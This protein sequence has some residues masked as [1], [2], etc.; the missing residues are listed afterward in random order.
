MDPLSTVSEFLCL[1]SRSR[2]LYS[3]A[4]VFVSHSTKDDS[5]VNGIRQ[6][7]ESLGVE[8]W[9]DSQRLT[10]GDPLTPNVMEAI[11]RSEHFLAILSKN[12]I[13]SPWVAKEIKH[14]LAKGKKVIPILLLP[15]ETTALPLWF[16]EEPVG[17]KLS[18]GPGGLSSA[19]P[20]LLA[21]LGLRQPAEKTAALQAKLAP[22]A[23]LTLRLADPSIDRSDGK[24]RA[25]ATAALVYSPSYSGPEVE[26]LRFRF[27]APLGPI[28][29]RR[30]FLVPGALHQLAQR[31][32]SGARAPHRGR[33]AAVGP[34][35]LPQPGWRG[36]QRHP[37]DLESRSERSRAPLHRQGR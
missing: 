20:D 21:A 17:L 19:L 7:L 16:A 34:R 32:L 26:S 14:G 37:E 28:E 6:T 27:T 12:A 33:T 24:R 10:A 13:N 29:A 4:V 18:I 11:E 35:A 36:R 15:I 1:A 3:V 22:I 25:A 31:H 2:L 23:D 9:I 8:V 5:I 30:P